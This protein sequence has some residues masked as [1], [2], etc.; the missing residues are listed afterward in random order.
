MYIVLYTGC[1]ANTQA[2]SEGMLHRIAPEVNIQ[3][4]Q[5]SVF[6]HSQTQG[7]NNAIGQVPTVKGGVTKAYPIPTRT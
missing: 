7:T 1:V 6:Q 3:Y 4:T 5:I 2:N